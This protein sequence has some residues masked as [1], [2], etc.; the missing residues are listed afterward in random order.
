MKNRLEI[1]DIVA[2]VRNVADSVLVRDSGPVSDRLACILC[3][4]LVENRHLLFRTVAIDHLDLL[5]NVMIV[6]AGHGHR[7]EPNRLDEIWGVMPN[8]S[9]VRILAVRIDL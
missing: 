1:R 9:D 2:S 4:R 8:V 7:I 5:R 6:H 3:R